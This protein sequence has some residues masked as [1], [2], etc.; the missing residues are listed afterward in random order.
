[1]CLY[2]LREGVWVALLIVLELLHQLLLWRH[3]LNAYCIAQKQANS[4][5]FRLLII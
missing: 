2:L 5:A 4:L 1:M 3:L